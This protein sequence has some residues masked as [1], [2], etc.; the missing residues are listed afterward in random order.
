MEHLVAAALAEDMTR[1]LSRAGGV[2]ILDGTQSTPQ[3][4]HAVLR[5]I[6][7]T[8]RIKSNRVIVV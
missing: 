5:A 2:A 8:K 1:F 7:K 6:K 3:R 4:R